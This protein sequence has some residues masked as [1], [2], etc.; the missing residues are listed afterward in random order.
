MGK[1]SSDKLHKHIK[2]EFKHKA[3]DKKE[4]QDTDIKLDEFKFRNYSVT[5]E[6]SGYEVPLVCYAITQMYKQN[7]RVFAGA[8]TLPSSPPDMMFVETGPK[9]KSKVLRD[10]L[11]IFKHGFIS[12]MFSGNT[13]RLIVTVGS[14]TK[15][16][17]DELHHQLKT[18]IEKNNFYQGKCLKLQSNGIVMLDKPAVT[19]DQVIVPEKVLDEYKTNTIDFLTNEK[20][21]A[22]S[23][24]RS[25]ILYGPPG[26]GKTSMIS[27]TFN[28]LHERNITTAYLTSD[29]FREKDIESVV[30]F[31]LD[32]LTPMVLC[33]EDI[34]LIGYSRDIAHSSV[35]GPLLSVLNGIEVFNKPIV[36][37]ATTNR[38]EVLDSALTRPCR[39]DR[40]FKFDYPDKEHLAMLFKSIL[41]VDLP[42]SIDSIDKLTG[43]HIKEIYLT[44]KILASKNNDQDY[45]KY[46]DRAIEIVKDNFYIG[47]PKTGFQSSKETDSRPIMVIDPL[48][49]SRKAEIDLDPDMGIE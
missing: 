9:E 33:F 35:I 22:D 7:P 29:I 46:I 18:A 25:V 40:R 28:Y 5:M 6:Y 17:F 10:G 49:F 32:Y 31:C 11:L 8:P 41:K 3:A 42:A 19:F 48:G 21:R 36:F 26:T 4:Q 39:I 1:I 34:D 43:A 37:I 20:M 47:A 30:Q 12:F 14:N 13:N 45:T 24:R 38:F 16:S 44:S 27:A 2:A 15:K 23:Q